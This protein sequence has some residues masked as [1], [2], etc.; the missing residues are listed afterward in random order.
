MR[1]EKRRFPAWRS[2]NPSR[3]TN[4]MNTT[5]RL[6][7]RLLLIGATIGGVAAC[8]PAPARVDPAPSHVDLTPMATPDART[9]GAFSAINNLAQ[10]SLQPEPSPGPFGKREY[11]LVG[12]ANALNTVD[13]Q[14][15]SADLNSAATEYIYALAELGAAINHH[16]STDGFN[17]GK[18]EMK[19][20]HK[21]GP[22]SGYL[23]G[24]GR[25][26][27]STQPSWDNSSTDA[28]AP[29]KRALPNDPAAQGN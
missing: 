15:V 11:D 4:P 7:R 27:R 28:T 6:F 5:A 2:Q 3:R 29:D 23:A 19:M 21:C 12:L 10:E 20:I 14:G 16:E 25:R 8:S 1:K 13:K 26:D 18:A 22:T 24:Q 17:L 9:C